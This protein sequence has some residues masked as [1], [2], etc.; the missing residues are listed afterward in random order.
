MML[1]VC[2]TTAVVYG[3][4]QKQLK[5]GF[6]KSMANEGYLQ[7]LVIAAAVAGLHFWTPA[8]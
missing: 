4:Q 8:M 2:E 7:W 3:V 5:A 1:A 6:S